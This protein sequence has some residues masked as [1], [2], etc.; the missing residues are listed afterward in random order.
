MR[1]PIRHSLAC[2]R[3]RRV[4]PTL[5]GR[6]WPVQAPSRL[7]N[8]P[9]QR[10]R[11]DQCRCAYPALPCQLRQHNLEQAYQVQKEAIALR[12]LRREQR[13]GIKMGFTSRAK[14]IQM[15]VSDLIWGRLTDAMH[16]AAGAELPFGRFIHPRAEPEIAF[17]LA[18]PG[19]SSR[20]AA[21][22]GS[23]TG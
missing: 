18:R 7:V 21:P 2:L 5:Q 1:R 11:N 16:L 6:Q 19:P 14:M 9:R 13:A 4:R 15:G 12:L 23:G 22:P 3:L 20:Q 17:R 10:R 8:P